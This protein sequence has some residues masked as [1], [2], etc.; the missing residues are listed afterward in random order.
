MVVSIRRH[1]FKSL[2]DLSWRSGWEE[3]RAAA[4]SPVS[5]AELRSRPPADCLRS[6]SL[7][8]CLETFIQRL[9]VTYRDVTEKMEASAGE[10]HQID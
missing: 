1:I 6:L 8:V 7:S 10:L 4:A 9:M 3:L 2:K 5:L